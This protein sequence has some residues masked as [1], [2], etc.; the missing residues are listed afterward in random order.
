MS[1]MALEILLKMGIIYIIIAVA[2]YVYQKWK[3][4]EDMKMT[5]QETKDERKQMEGDP[6]VK[7]QFRSLM[8]NRIRKLMIDNV[9]EA[10]VVITNPTHFAVAIK[11]DQIAS[12]APV[13][14]AKGLDFIA[15]Q[16]REKAKETGVPI[17]ENPPLARAIYRNVE[18]DE[19]IPEELFKAVAEVLAY[20]Y[21]LKEVE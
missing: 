5:K 18:V 13:L 19:E 9:G 14:L 4:G 3:F 1:S 17:V 8:R 10:D 11:Y 2:D 21:S 6:K 12:G 20:V 15:Y 7:A 16:I